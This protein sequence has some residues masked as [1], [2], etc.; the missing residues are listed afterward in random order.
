MRKRALNIVSFRPGVISNNTAFECMAL[1]YKYLQVHHGYTFTIIKS[2]HDHYEDP[3]L[4]VISIP[5][6][7]WKP[8]PHTPFFRPSLNRRN[9]LDRLLGG[10]DGILTVDPTIYP[11]GLLALRAARTGG[12][13]VWFDASV[14]LMGMGRTI[15]WKIA[16][17]AVRSAIHEASG[18]IITVPKCIE[19]FQDQALFDDQ[20]ASKFHLMG[21]PVDCTM[22][23]PSMGNGNGDG[24][25]RVL[26]VSRLVPEKGFFYILDAM[27]P[28]MKKNSGLC[29]QILGDG[30][31][32]PLLEKEIRQRWLEPQVEF[33]APVPHAKL[34]Q[35]MAAADIFVNHAVGTTGWEEFFGVVNL[36]A[37]ACGLPCVLSTSGGLTHVVRG[38]GV[39]CLVAE[40]DVLGVRRAL[41]NLIG[42][43]ESRRAM[44]RRARRYVKENYDIS[45]IGEKYRRMLEE[46]ASGR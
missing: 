12:K 19:R 46:G 34:P 3:A 23:R 29:L 28:L 26:V 25:V 33:L 42:D 35:I 18:I 21:H 40:R 32:K 39:A 7:L 2:D 24:R 38:D 31:L 1:I 9:R 5:D 37:M 8:I 27:Q 13:P 43:L 15:Q 22:F 16:K 11:Q 6:A 36:E 20:L 17:R 44:G 45:V 41:R 10:S 30:P 14:T 4:K